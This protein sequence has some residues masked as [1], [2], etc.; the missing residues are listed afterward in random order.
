M[1]LRL[2]IMAALLVPLLG[3]ALPVAHASPGALGVTV[4]LT[5]A[6]QQ[7]DPGAVF[8]L[9]IE[10][11]QAGDPFNGFEAVIGYDPAALTLLTTAQSAWQG[12]Y[13]TGAC[14][15]TFA[16]FTPEASQITIT[17]VLLCNGVE[18]PGPGQLCHLQFR[19]S[20]TS[21]VTTVQFLAGLQF[22][23][24]GLYVNPV[25]ASNANITI[26]TGPVPAVP[27]SWGRVKKIYR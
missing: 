16:I 23:N 22:Y 25:N 11:T 19:A 24:A 2:R 5:P 21:Q 8:D 9:Y 13:M 26:S 15:N 12:T 3:A 14:G 20:T 27:V 10:V 17:D 4:G 6:V 18:L 7:V 1:K